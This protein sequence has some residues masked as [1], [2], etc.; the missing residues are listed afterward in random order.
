[1]IDKYGTT[2]P[3]A[4]LKTAINRASDDLGDAIMSP[5]DGLTIAQAE[6]IAVDLRASARRISSVR[7]ILSEMA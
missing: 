1:M 7:R 5:A 3:F 4:T 2:I 6:R